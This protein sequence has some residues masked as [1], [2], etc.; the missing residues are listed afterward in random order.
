MDDLRTLLA[1]RLRLLRHSTLHRDRQLN[2][3]DLYCCYLHTP[4]LRML[5][6]DRL[7]FA[8]DLVALRQQFI[9]FGLTEHV[10]QRRLADLRR[11]LE[12]VHHVYNSSIGIYDVEVDDG[13]DLNCDIIARDH[14][15]WRHGKSDDT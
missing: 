12:E 9:Q 6:N 13:C 3:L 2:I 10:T 11:R 15:L 5:I 7:Q 8:I 1:F 4:T 14:L